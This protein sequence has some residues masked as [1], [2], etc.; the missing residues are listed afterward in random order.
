MVSNCVAAK[1]K[2]A[3]K[4]EMTAAASMDEL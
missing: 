1:Q 3:S 4:W 2:N